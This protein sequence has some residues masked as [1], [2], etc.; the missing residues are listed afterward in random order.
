MV[1]CAHYFF[2]AVRQGE[3]RNDSEGGTHKLGHMLIGGRWQITVPA[4]VTQSMHKVT[5]GTASVTIW[6]SSVPGR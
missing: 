1:N 5:E 3:L 4:T 2:C 6:L